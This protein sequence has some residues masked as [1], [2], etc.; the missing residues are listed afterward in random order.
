MAYKVDAGETGSDANDTGLASES[1]LP[2]TLDFVHISPYL[3]GYPDD[4]NKNSLITVIHFDSETSRTGS[5]TVHHHGLGPN[6]W[7]LR[8]ET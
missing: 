7:F 6:S 8:Y 1:P 4:V 2:S 5:D 3:T